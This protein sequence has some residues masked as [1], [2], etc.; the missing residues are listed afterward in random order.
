MPFAFIVKLFLAIFLNMATLLTRVKKTH[1]SFVL[2]YVS[3]DPRGK[4][5]DNIRLLDKKPDT[6]IRQE[7]KLNYIT[8]TKTGVGVLFVSTNK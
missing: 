2:L 4:T 1:R 3:F 5:K 8:C 7:G 6:A